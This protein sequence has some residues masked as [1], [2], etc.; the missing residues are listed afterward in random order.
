MGIFKS[1]ILVYLMIWFVVYDLIN[2]KN[3]LIYDDKVFSEKYKWAN[4]IYVDAF[5]YLFDKL[6]LR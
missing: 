1:N 6:V 4:M 3:L 5:V 2:R